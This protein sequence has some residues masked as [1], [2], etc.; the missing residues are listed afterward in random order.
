MIVFLSRSRRKDQVR[1]THYIGLFLW[2]GGLLLVGGWALFESI[3]R[4]SHFVTL[5]RQVEIGAG[6]VIA[7]AV[8]VMVSLIVER[9]RDYRAEKELGS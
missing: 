9:A 7:G 6:L 5:P 3:R 8:M 4:A 1:P 2:R